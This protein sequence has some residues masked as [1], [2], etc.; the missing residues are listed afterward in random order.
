MHFRRWTDP[1]ELAPIASGPTLA[2][3]VEVLAG[4]KILL[5]TR[6]VSGGS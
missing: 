3:S 6:A 2:T 1:G 5:A 4:R